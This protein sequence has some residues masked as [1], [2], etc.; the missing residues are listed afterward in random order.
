MKELILILFVFISILSVAQTPVIDSNFKYLQSPNNITFGYST[1]DSVLWAKMGT[2]GWYRVSNN[3]GDSSKIVNCFYNKIPIA[4]AT[5]SVAY[6]KDFSSDDY[7]LNIKAFYNKTMYGKVM[8]IE[9]ATYDFT[10]TVSGFSLKV[11]TVAGYLEYLAV[12][13]TSLYPL[14]FGNYIPRSDVVVTVGEVGSDTKVP[15]EKAVR[16]A[17]AASNSGGTGLDIL[18]ENPIGALNGSNTTFV[19]QYAPVL[20]KECI[21]FNGLR[22]KPTE[23]YF[24]AN[25]YITLNYPPL[26]GD[27]LS[28]DYSVYQTDR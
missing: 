16:T 14:S 6:P 9:N 17:I 27:L 4:T 12:D 15:S 19:L 10:K 13:S 18:G 1:T 8:S 26:S 22:L 24:I 2:Y 21:Y 23:D 3:V 25:E 11:D 20:N 7:S 28:V 5:V